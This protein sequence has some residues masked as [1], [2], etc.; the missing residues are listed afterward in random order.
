MTGHDNSAGLPDKAAHEAPGEAMAGVPED[1]AA[2]VPHRAAETAAAILDRLAERLGGRASV[3]TVFGEP[4]TRDGITVIP[5]AESAFGFGGGTGRELGPEKDGEGGGGGGGAAAKPVGYIEIGEGA[6]VY[7]PIRRPW[8]EAA[9]PVAAVLVALIVSRTVRALAGRHTT[10]HCRHWAA[11][12]ALRAAT[13]H[14]LR[15]AAG[16]GRQLIAR[17]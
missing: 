13:R 17:G 9:G 2:Q 4:V 6:A 14:R 11:K 5:V 10:G 1:A 8:T 12:H 16:R 3:T 7:R 15:T